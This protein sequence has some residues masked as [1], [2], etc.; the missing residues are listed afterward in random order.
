MRK[1]KMEMVTGYWPDPDSLHES[2]ELGKLI[3]I[4]KYEIENEN[5]WFYIDKG[6]KREKNAWAKYDL[7]SGE[8]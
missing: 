1:V 6:N 8:R 5:I 4:Q 7:F 3:G 2:V